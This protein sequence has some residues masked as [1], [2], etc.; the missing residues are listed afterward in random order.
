M[1]EV[2]ILGGTGA[3]GSYLVSVLKINYHVVVTSRKKRCDSENVTYLQGNAHNISFLKEILCKKYDAIID[4][5]H[6]TT[7]EFKQRH[8]MLLNSCN[9]LVFI[10][11]ARGLC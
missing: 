5:M 8:E 3:M 7:A 2:L 6:Y 9:Q 11:S 1:N 10:S 4:F